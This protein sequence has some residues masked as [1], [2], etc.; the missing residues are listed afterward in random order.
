VTEEYLGAAQ[1][2]TA[3]GKPCSEMY[4]GAVDIFGQGLTFMQRIDMDQYAELRRANLY[5]P[6]ALKQDWE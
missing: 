3:A 2:H 1:V 6:I 5:Y 4:D